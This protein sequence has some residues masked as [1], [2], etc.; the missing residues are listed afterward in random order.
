MYMNNLFFHFTNIIVLKLFYY[1][2]HEGES[3]DDFLIAW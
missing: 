3:V 1:K 2:Q